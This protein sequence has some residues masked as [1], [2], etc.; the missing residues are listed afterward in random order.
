MSC[1]KILCQLKLECCLY[2]TERGL[3]K[4]H[5]LVHK[6]GRAGHS[7]MNAAR[8]SCSLF[9]TVFLL[10]LASGEEMVLET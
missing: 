8:D 7:V 1:D 6:T 4:P 9:V 3:D 10:T 2:L 5:F